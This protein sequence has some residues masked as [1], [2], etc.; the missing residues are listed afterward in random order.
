[1][2]L[3]A[4]TTLRL[5]F[6][7]WQG[8][9]NPP[10]H[11]GAQLLSWLAPEHSGPQ[12]EVPVALPDPSGLAV[13]NGIVGRGA[14]LAQLHAARRLIDKHQPDRLVVLGGDCLVDLAPFAYLNERYEGN[15]AVLWV[16]THPD[17]MTP[18]QFEHA[19]AMVLGNLL[20]Q[21]DPDFVAAVARPIK[22]GNV[23][24]LGLHHPGE[25]EAG[26]MARLGLQTVSPTLLAEQ[27][28]QPV[29]DWFKATGATHL[30]IHLDLDV[31]DPTLFR[32]LLF[33]KPGIA[34]DAFAG[35]AQGE[36]SM[37]QVIHALGEVA[38]VADVVGLGI[39]EHLP[40]DALALK[41]MLA[42]LP[43]IGRVDGANP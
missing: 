36:L 31:L 14:L 12:E 2:T 40:W 38:A 27:G 23:M 35:V 13:D 9:N 32:A 4:E 10:Y 21:G 11:F 18:A 43:L 3:K 15:L 33:A 5:L 30:A 41:N 29:L 22:A 37:E 28:S 6:P 26:E 7:Q 8:G 34:D 17:I 25:W 19:H 1:M 16:D 42:R 39:A 24:F 20:G